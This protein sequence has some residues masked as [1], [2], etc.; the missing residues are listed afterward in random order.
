ML[1]HYNSVHANEPNFQ[2]VCSVDG[3]PAKFTL[4]NSFY[5]HIL[6][7]HKQYYNEEYSNCDGNQQHLHI[8]VDDDDSSVSSDSG[9]YMGANVWSSDSDE[10]EYCA[11]TNMQVKYQIIYSSSDI[12]YIF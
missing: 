11:D 1:R 9:E 3:C 8:D 2:V 6:K 12:L 5:K 4:Y 10:D 7:K